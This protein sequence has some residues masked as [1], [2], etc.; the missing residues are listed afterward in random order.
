MN[1]RVL[2]VDD[3][4]VFRRVVS[5]ALSGIPD[6]EV[7][8]VA[9][10]GQQALER[11]KTML[12]DVIT[13][14]LEMPG[15]NGLGVLE[16]LKAQKSDLGVVV[17]SAFSIKGGE[18]TMRALELGAFDFITKPTGGDPQSNQ[19]AIRTALTP[20]FNAFRR[21]KEI[22]GILK[23]GTARA[24]APNALKPA[25]ANAA[26]SSRE[27]LT[28]VAQRMER[29][30]GAT[31]PEMILVGV[32]T[33]GPAALAEV[34]PN[35]PADFPVPVLIVQHM[36]PLFTQSLA[37]S[38]AN[39]S[40]LGVKEA[41]DGDA[42]QPGMVY[43]APGGRHMKVT[44]GPNRDKVIKI[45]DDPPENC[46]RPA[47][48]YL[49]RSVSVH[50]P[51]R[52]AAVIMTGMGNDGTVGLRL[53]KRAGCRVIAQDEASCVVYGMP[54]EAVAAGVVDLSVPLH[55]IAAEIVKTAKGISA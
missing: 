29:L 14:D 11:I 9:S 41:T 13:L 7:L 28:S 12:P 49:F 44:P 4:V 47:V 30:I 42:A 24:L 54:K 23:Q 16:A 17:I 50:F 31:K 53:L 22:Q 55:Q 26:V 43:I 5:D 34:I 3:S 6:V 20:I 27:S 15:L 45:T 35:L 8:G 46:C 48:D 38:L 52:A 39:K 33:G 36:P 37:A 40:R 1:L 2:V 25:Q 19:N 10:G 18:M 51:G 32:S 21:K